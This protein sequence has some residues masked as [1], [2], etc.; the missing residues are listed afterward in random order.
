MRTNLPNTYTDR[1]ET[2]CCAVANIVDWD[3]KEIEFNNMRF[4]RMYTKSFLHIPLNMG[5]IMKLLNEAAT[6][7][8]KLMPPQQ[9]M[10]LSRDISAWKAEQL[11]GVT[12]EV[13][14]MDNITLSGKFLSMVFEGPYQDA[15]KWHDQ[16]NNFAKTK[17]YETGELYFFYTTCP[18]CAKHYGKNYTIGLVSID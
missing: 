4:I 1:N 16:L 11:Y 5:K 12:D 9:A 14:G 8:G 2:G 13:E 15:E 10:I 6:K 18:K 7:S 3:K 17:G